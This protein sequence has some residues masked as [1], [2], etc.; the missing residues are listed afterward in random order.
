MVG[1]ALP[2]ASHWHPVGPHRLHYLDEGEGA[3]VLM[4]HGNPSWC[5]YYRNLVQRLAPRYRCV[6]PD[7]IGMGLS[8]KPD[9]GEY[10]YTL[11]QRLADLDSLVRHLDLRDITLVVHDWGGMIGL[12]WA[13]RNPERVKRLVLLN[14]GAFPLP[15]S[16]PLPLGLKLCRLPLLGPLLVQGANAFARG[17][18]WVGCKRQRLDKARRDQFCAPYDSWAHRRAVLRFVQDIPL[19]AADPAF[20]TVRQTEERLPLLADRPTLILWGERDFVFDRHFLARWRTI[21]P[22][23]EL[24]RFADCG[25]YVLEDAGS[26][27]LDR[28]DAFLRRTEGDRP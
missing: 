25:H 14:T 8:D 1:A 18:A 23:A 15:A 9:D 6:V 12:A 28:I 19:T 4:V 16:K 24:H 7:H 17:A 22:Q 26:E 13:V 20:A 5:F 2:F 27:A 3:P 11:D 10:H 21:Y